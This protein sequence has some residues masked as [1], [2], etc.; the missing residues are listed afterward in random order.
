MPPYTT[1]RN[2]LKTGLLSGQ[3]A[4][5]I[6]ACGCGISSAFASEET[7][8]DLTTLTR[9]LVPGEY[10]SK[11]KLVLPRFRSGLFESI[12]CYQGDHICH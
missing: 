9:V 6:S 7:P 5:F 12:I 10:L 1:R 4:P 11:G 8:D 2:F 3:S